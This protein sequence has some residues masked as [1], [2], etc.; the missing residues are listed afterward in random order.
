MS[1]KATEQALAS[2]LP[3]LAEDLPNELVR[4]AASLLAQ[5]RSFGGSLKPEAEIARVYV[6]AELACKRCALLCYCS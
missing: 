5:S 6:C 2:L 3:T 4:H 1:H